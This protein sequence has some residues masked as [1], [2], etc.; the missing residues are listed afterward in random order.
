MIS[1]TF[2]EAS[3]VVIKYLAELTDKKIKIIESERIRFSEKQSELFLHYS[4]D[5]NFSIETYEI[6]KVIRDTVARG[7]NIDI[8]VIP[9]K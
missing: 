5:N 1:A 6:Q 3:K 9:K 7:K 2:N 8:Y 4:N